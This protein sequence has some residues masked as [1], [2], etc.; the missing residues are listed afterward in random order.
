MYG[1]LLDGSGPGG[2]YYADY[3]LGGFDREVLRIDPVDPDD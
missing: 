2:E 3:T 1:E